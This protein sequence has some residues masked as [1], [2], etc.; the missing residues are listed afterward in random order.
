M[1]SLP[2]Q[3]PPD[4]LDVLPEAP[5]V[6]LFYGDNPLP[7]YIG[8]SINL[9]E[10]VGAH[11]SQRLAQRDRPAA[12]AG[13]PPDRVRGNRRRARR[14]VARS[15]ADQVAA[16]R[17]QPRVAPQARS[18]RARNR[19]WRAAVRRR[20]RHRLREAVGQLRSV[21]IARI[22]ARERCANSRPT[23]G[24]VRCGCE[25]ERRAGGP[26]FARQLAR[27]DG[28]CVGAESPASHDQRL[29]DALA[30]LMIPRWP[31]AGL[32]LVRECGSGRTH[33]RS[34]VSRLVLARHCAR[35][36]RA[37]GPG[38][39]AAVRR[40]RSRRR[41]AARAAASCGYPAP[42]RG[43]RRRRRTPRSAGIRLEHV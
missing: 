37:C 40:V 3:L 27:C 22:G 35:R 19:R 23:T 9:R 43:A 38:R 13:D 8:K 14:A 30:P 39:G 42:H 41:E 11:F 6:Y 17:V 28:A 36:R 18:R 34:P 31:A 33:R 21:R 24:C 29:A 25:L 2:P 10:R 16:A 1:P 4:A 26:C 32:A 5:G 7:L 15:G 20:R 12:V